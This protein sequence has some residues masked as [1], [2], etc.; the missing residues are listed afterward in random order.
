MKKNT[1]YYFIAV[2]VVFIWSITFIST[3]VLLKSLSPIEIMFYRYVIAY[4]TLIIVYPKIHKSS[5]LKEELLFL[6][7]GLFGGTIYFLAE[8]YA[9]KFSLASNVGLLVAAAPLLTAITAYLF[10]KE[11]KVNSGWYLGALV[12]FLGVFLVMFNGKF[13]LKLNPIGDFLAILAALSWAIYSLIIKAIGAKYSGIYITR[14][15]FFYSILTMI[16]VLFVT[17]FKWNNEILFDK[18]II[19]NILFLGILASSI[20][21]VLWN[22]VILKIGAIK[23]NNFIYLIP[24]ITMISSAIMLDEP[25]KLISVIG[26]LL[27]IFGVYISENKNNKEIV[28]S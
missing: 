6:G 2:F 22:K 7:S 3:K 26:G 15:V 4:I 13:I 20:C 27:I 16:P 10:M 25:I 23:S 18:S 17:D 21:F 5:G 1:L 19:F 28:K 24:L 14:K 9:L 12:A 11:E 8:N